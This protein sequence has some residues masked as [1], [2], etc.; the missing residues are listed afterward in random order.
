M[1]INSPT[2]GNIFKSYEKY[3][4]HNIFAITFNLNC[5]SGT[6]ISGGPFCFKLPPTLNTVLHIALAL[7]DICLIT[8]LDRDII[9]TDIFYSA[10]SVNLLII[11]IVI[12]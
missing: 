4:L 2:V 10:I 9:Y 11:N 8:Y 6:L 1:I 5:K 3:D 7:T 12:I